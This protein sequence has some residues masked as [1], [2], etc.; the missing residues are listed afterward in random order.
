MI[1]ELSQRFYFE[2]AHTLDR[3]IDAAGSRRVHGH[4]YH[5]EVTIRG[6]RDPQ[7]GMVLDLG[8]LRREIETLRTQLDHALLDDVPGLGT[9]TLENLCAFLASRLTPLLP[10]LARVRVWREASGDSCVLHLDRSAD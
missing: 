8:W 2:A 7:T 1:L 6:P 5:A 9:P 4:T 3:Q 10:Q